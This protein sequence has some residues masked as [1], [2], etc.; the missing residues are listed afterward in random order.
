MKNIALITT[1]AIFTLAACDDK[2]AVKPA[3][4]APTMTQTAP[5]IKPGTP[6]PPGHPDINSAGP[7]DSP[8]ATLSGM[9]DIEQPTE[10]VQ[11]QEATVISS[12]DIPQF[13]YLEV[14][15]DGKTRWIA[16]ATLAVKKGD[17]IDFDEGSTMSNFTSKSL[18]RTFPSITFV[19]N[20]SVGNKK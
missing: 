4:P 7:M 17:I 8:A 10:S 19:N 12:I 16:S 20:A 18:N 13:T 2:P 15:Q 5:P 14:K 11:T 3:A 1:L 9:T 6:M